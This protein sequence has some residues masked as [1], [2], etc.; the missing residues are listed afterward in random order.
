V[1]LTRR[2][3][4]HPEDRHEGVRAQA[5]LEE[6][7]G[8]LLRQATAGLAEL[9]EDEGHQVQLP[10]GVGAHGR[11]GGRALDQ[12]GL[13]FDPL[14]AVDRLLRPFLVDLQLVRLDVRN[15][16]ALLVAHHDVEDDRRRARKD[17]LS[18]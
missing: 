2:A 15:R 1:R 8:R 13:G 11:R 6:A 18:S 3:V 4:V 12:H 9:V 7:L 10:R 14:E 16:A 17:R 5:L